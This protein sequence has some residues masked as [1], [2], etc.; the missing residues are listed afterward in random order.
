ML[1]RIWRHGKLR[2]G[3]GASQSVSTFSTLCSRKAS[4]RSRLMSCDITDFSIEIFFVAGRP[5]KFKSRSS[6]AAIRMFVSNCAIKS[7]L[8]LIK[9]MSPRFL[10][11]VFPSRQRARISS[12]SDWNSRW[13]LRKFSSVLNIYSVYKSKLTPRSH[14][15]LHPHSYPPTFGEL[16]LP[17]SLFQ[18]CLARFLPLRGLSR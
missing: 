15:R 1:S 17:V 9:L 13:F 18:L 2:F 3:S 12:K 16:F 6:S 10:R 14:L 8:S 4:C 5:S 7:S 11:R